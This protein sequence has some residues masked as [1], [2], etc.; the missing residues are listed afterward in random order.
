MAPLKV[1]TPRK[2][3]RPTK[4]TNRTLDRLEEALRKGLP[5]WAACAYA[6]IS[7]Q[8]FYEWLQD[9]EFEAQVLEWEAASMDDLIKAVKKEPKGNQFL[10]ARRFRP[11]YGDKVEVETKG[12]QTVNVV[13]THDR[14]DPKV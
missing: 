3:G 14:P 6:K 12:E 11:D 8:A 2:R 5:R 1:R 7:R 4:K 9:P 10:L 13:V